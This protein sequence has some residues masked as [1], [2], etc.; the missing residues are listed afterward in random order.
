VSDCFEFEQKEKRKGRIKKKTKEEQRKKRKEKNVQQL[1][2]QTK[3]RVASSS[4]SFPFF[5][6][7]LV[8]QMKA[9]LF[10]FLLV[11]ELLGYKLRLQTHQPVQYFKTREGAIQ[12][13]AAQLPSAPYPDWAVHNQLKIKQYLFFFVFSFQ[14]A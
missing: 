10:F 1:F 11:E 13:E 2:R 3:L 14:K 5:F 12:V 9:L 6:F 8:F 7:L 4:R